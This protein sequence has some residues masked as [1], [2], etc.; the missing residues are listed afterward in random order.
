MRLKGQES[1]ASRHRQACVGRRIQSFDVTVTTC[2]EFEPEDYQQMAGLAF[3][4]DVETWYYL[5]IRGTDEGGIG[6]NLKITDMQK[7][8]ELLEQDLPLESGRIF[9][10]GRMTNDELRLAWSTDGEDWVR[11]GDVF[12]ASRLSDEYGNYTRNG[13]FTGAFTA[14]AC[15]DLSGRRKHADFDFLRYEEH[16]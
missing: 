1:L 5:H 9:L 11:I 15:H 10:R 16:I 13:N 12:D 3:I 4:Y 7:E 14:L 8:S 6:L 2:L